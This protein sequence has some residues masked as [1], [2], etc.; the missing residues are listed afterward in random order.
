MLHS[1][2]PDWNILRLGIA[3][4]AMAVLAGCGGIAR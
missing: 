1:R 3:A 4:A 2:P